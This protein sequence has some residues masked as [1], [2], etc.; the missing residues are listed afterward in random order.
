[1]TDRSVP[2]LRDV[3]DRFARIACERPLL[4]DGQFTVALLTFESQ[5]QLC[6]AKAAAR[7]FERHTR[8]RDPKWA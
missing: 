4:A 2:S 3:N 5:L 8:G 1:M 7:T 6:E